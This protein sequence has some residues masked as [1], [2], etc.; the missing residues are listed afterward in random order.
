MA[1]KR[2]LQKSPEVIPMNIATFLIRMALMM[3]ATYCWWNYNVV[4]GNAVA[5]ERLN[6]FTGVNEIA[7]LYLIPMMGSI[8]QLYWDQDAEI[9]VLRHPALGIFCIVVAI[10]D[11]LGP[12]YGFLISTARDFTLANIILALLWGFFFSVITQEVAW[13]LAKDLFFW[14]KSQLVR[15]P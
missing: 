12:A 5:I 15:N 10:L 7:R 3:I 9:G 11:T 14:A 13:Q 6:L 8:A 2:V 1:A 4:Y